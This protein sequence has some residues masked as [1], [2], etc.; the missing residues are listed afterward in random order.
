MSTWTEQLDPKTAAIIE[1]LRLLSARAMSR[2]A[3]QQA[4]NEDP[5]DQLQR[6]V[7]LSIRDT[8]C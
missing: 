6:T 4:F 7:A 2:A 1:K 5:S 8:V 3:L